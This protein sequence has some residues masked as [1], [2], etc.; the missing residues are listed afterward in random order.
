MGV[1][2][3][4]SGFVA[5]GEGGVMLKAANGSDWAAAGQSGSD[6]LYGAV[7]GGTSLIAVGI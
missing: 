2:F 6:W 7:L 1:V 3:D 5:L 4:G